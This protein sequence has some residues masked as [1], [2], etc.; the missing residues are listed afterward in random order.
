M[1]GQ[2]HVL[3]IKVDVTRQDYVVVV[4]V[5]VAIR[6]ELQAETADGE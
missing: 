3:G 5:T 4:R 2:D 1:C 6:E